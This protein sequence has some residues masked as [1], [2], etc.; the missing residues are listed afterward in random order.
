MIRR[1]DIGI[2]I[3]Y[4]IQRCWLA[5]VGHYTF[6]ELSCPQK[7]W[8]SP[9]ELSCTL[10]AKNKVRVAIHNGLCDV[11]FKKTSNIISMINGPFHP[12]RTP[13]N[14]PKPS[15]LRCFCYTLNHWIH[16]F[17][18]PGRW[19]PSRRFPNS[20]PACHSANTRGIDRSS[21]RA[22]HTSPPGQS[23]RKPQKWHARDLIRYT[24][25]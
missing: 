16:S 13:Q 5:N 14:H 17:R 8:I 7:P 2:I 11:S 4:T 25:W 20:G 21:H 6:H 9:L 1:N 22:N 12:F 24:L 15:F 3:D 18:H 23:I 19:S 10:L